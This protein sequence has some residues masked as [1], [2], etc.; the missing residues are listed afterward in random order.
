MAVIKAPAV[1]LWLLSRCGTKGRTRA[2]ASP[3]SGPF[4]TGHLQ[5][6][7]PFVYRPA[8]DDAKL[9]HFGTRRA[10]RIGS[11]CTNLSSPAVWGAAFVYFQ[12]QFSNLRLIRLL[13]Q[14][15][16]NSQH[17]RV[18]HLGRFHFDFTHSEFQLSTIS[19]IHPSFLIQYSDSQPGGTQRNS[20]IAKN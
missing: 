7:K 6:A 8:D 17:V 5:R 4:C 19:S 13:L 11:A 12:K 20:K 1:A 9:T 15:L 10:L 14:K 16:K 3:L 18:A 2:A